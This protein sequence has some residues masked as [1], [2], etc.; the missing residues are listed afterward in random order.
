MEINSAYLAF[1]IEFFFVCRRS[2]KYHWNL[3]RKKMKFAIEWTCFCFIDWIWYI[4][5]NV[6]ISFPF[7]FAVVTY[8]DGRRYSIIVKDQTVSHKYNLVGSFLC[9]CRVQVWILDSHFCTLNV[10]FLSLLDYLIIEKKQRK[11]SNLPT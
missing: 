4:L 10:S 6:K 3:W 1:C 8:E 2:W 9:S 11:R 7:V 5:M